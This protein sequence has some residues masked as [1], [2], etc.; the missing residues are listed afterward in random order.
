[1]KTKKRDP[2]LGKTHPL[3]SLSRK[4]GP[5]QLAQV[6]K[7]GASMRAFLDSL[8]D[9][10]GAHELRDLARR[11]AVARRSRR[12]VLLQMGAH[13]LK[14]GLGPII[15]ALIRDGIITAIAGN[16]ATLIHD[17]ELAY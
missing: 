15:C 7:A 13:P 2:S 6:I 17:F 4:V 1:M 12:T 3:K 16:G 14:V 5:S 11:I 9:V 8:P 10:L